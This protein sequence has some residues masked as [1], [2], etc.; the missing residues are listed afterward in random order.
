MIPGDVRSVAIAPNAAQ[1][2]TGDVIPFSLNVV[3]KANSEKY[4]SPQIHTSYFYIPEVLE[5]LAL[6][7]RQRPANDI[8][9]RTA[10]SGTSFGFTMEPWQSATAGKSSRRGVTESKQASSD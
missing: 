5:D 6:T 3:D 10:I 9:W 1:V 7:S 8:W 2:R 4:N